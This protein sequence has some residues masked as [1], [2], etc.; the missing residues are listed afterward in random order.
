MAP[1]KLTVVQASSSSS[2]GGGGSEWKEKAAR[3]ATDAAEA[4]GRK[5][6]QLDSEYGVTQKAEK[7][8]KRLQ[9]QAI[10]V[11]GLSVVC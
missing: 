4:A 2:S 11:G 10:D 9:E 6:R 8:A 5:F 1:C 7:A 3:L